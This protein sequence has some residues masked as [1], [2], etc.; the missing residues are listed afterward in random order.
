MQ[1]GDHIFCPKCC[2]TPHKDQ[3]CT[4]QKAQKHSFKNTQ[5]TGVLRTEELTSLVLR[6]DEDMG[7]WN[8]QGLQIPFIPKSGVEISFKVCFYISQVHRK[9]VFIFASQKH[10]VTFSNI[11]ELQRS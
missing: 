3:F 1:Y 7:S 9:H 11:P 10:K 4:T 2:K 5:I 8:S 6:T